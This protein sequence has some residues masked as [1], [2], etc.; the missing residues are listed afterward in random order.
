MYD[1]TLSILLLVGIFVV[2]PIGLLFLRDRISDLIWS[3]RNPPEKLEAERKEI[4]KRIIAPDWDFYQEHLSRP[5][6]P[7]LKELWSDSDL[8]TS[9]GVDYD[10][11]NWISTFNPLTKENLIEHKEVFD[12]EIVP[13]LTTGFGDPV[14][15]KP[16]SNEADCLYITYH[17]GGETAVFE[18]SVDQFVKT[19]KAKQGDALNSVRMLAST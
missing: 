4:E 14:Y 18:E 19:L 16:G 10:E 6:P 8:V 12:I 3:K 13:I 15:L 17:D 7:Q 1:T 11:D 5:V 2:L 9:C